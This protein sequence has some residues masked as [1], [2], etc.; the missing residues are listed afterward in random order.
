[1]RPDTAYGYVFDIIVSSDLEYGGTMDDRTAATIMENQETE[2]ASTAPEDFT[3]LLGEEKKVYLASITESARSR[4]DINP[5]LPDIEHR[6]R[7]SLVE[8]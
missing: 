7:V 8:T 6:V 4:A 5:A 2:R 1:M 3:N